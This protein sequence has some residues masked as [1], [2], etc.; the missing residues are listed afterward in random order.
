MA[1][2]RKAG[3]AG[4]AAPGTGRR[5]CQPVLSVILRTEAA[6]FS[7]AQHALP[8]CGAL[9]RP[10]LLWTNCASLTL[11]PRSA[12]TR[13]FGERG[14]W[15]DLAKRCMQVCCVGRTGRA[16]LQRAA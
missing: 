1:A 3:M 15:N 13:Y 16:P 5:L 14:W 4:G 7:A 8:G 6:C 2:T 9:A 11:P 10:A 12:L